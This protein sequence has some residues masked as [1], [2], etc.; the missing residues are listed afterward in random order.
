[1]HIRFLL[2]IFIIIP[3]NSICQNFNNSNF[4]IKYQ[5]LEFEVNPEALYISGVVTTYFT[6]IAN[7]NQITFEL[8]DY[9]NVDSIVF[10]NMFIDYEHSENQLHIILSE[11]LYAGSY[12]SVS[13][14]YHG[15]PPDKNSRAFEID[16]HNG[17]PIMW[18][19]SEPYGAKDWMPCKQTLND[20]I[21][22]VDIFVTTPVQYKVASIGILVSE[23]LLNGKKITHWKHNFPVAAYLI[24]FAI[25][26]YEIYSD[27]ANLQNDNYF[28][29]LN[30]VYPEDIDYAKL[31][32][33]NVIDVIEFFDSLLIP[34]PFERYGHAQFE[35][36]GGM[37]N[38]T[39]SF[40]LNFSHSLMAH[41][42]A[43]Q[44][45][46]DYIT[47]ASWH[48][49]WLNESFATYFEGLTAEKG[50]ADYSWETWKNKNIS[51]ATLVEIGSV[52]VID[53]TSIASIFNH[54]LVYAKGAMVL[55]TLR[56]Q[57]GDSLFFESIRNYLK[58]ENLAYGYACT[59]DLIS[60]FENTANIDLTEFFDDWIYGDGYP[61]YDIWWSQKTDNTLEIKINQNQTS[62]KVEFFELKIPII[63]KGYFSDTLI[64]FDNLF[65]GQEFNFKTNFRVE[66]AVF[67]PERTIL[68]RGSEIRKIF[69]S[70]DDFEIF[71]SPNPASDFI[72]IEFPT[73]VKIK[74]IELIN[75]FGKTLIKQNIN[76][77]F[78]NYLLNVNEILPGLYILKIKI[79]N[80]LL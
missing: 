43:H 69:D 76:T 26:N 29:I 36:G 20:K 3:F 31:N 39:M 57:I 11:Y 8:T 48:D 70:A 19:L 5:R 25:T 40:M 61:V 13:V 28:Q 67:D 37:E 35:W 17:I 46:G 47:C 68:T 50:L 1:M 66:N 58:D 6:I 60:H 2:L 72:Y 24:A 32:T 22:S 51:E 63:F 64:I 79:E 44:W 53:T 74:E 21:D 15:V 42:L 75:L 18:T 33:P 12:D 38:Q 55:N 9:L 80:Q 34:Y 73:V 56:G 45:F 10:N 14:Y 59:D 77:S 71:V 16:K 23:E 7:S 54:K 4:D 27:Y 78:S 49:I 30:Y 52:Y 41:E 62:E 65:N